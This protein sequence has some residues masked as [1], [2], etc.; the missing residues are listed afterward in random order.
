[1][2]IGSS[3]LSR[4]KRAAMRETVTATICNTSTKKKNSTKILSSKK[5][6]TSANSNKKTT[7]QTKEN[8]KKKAEMDDAEM[9]LISDPYRKRT[10]YC[11]PDIH[12]KK[13]QNC[14]DNPN[15][16]YGFVNSKV[17]IWGSHIALCNLSLGDNPHA[18]KRDL[19]SLKP[20]G[21]VNLGATCYVN[22]LLQVLFFD[23]VFRNALYS[24]KP[25]RLNNTSNN[26]NANN[27]NNFSHDLCEENSLTLSQKEIIESMQTTFAH[28][29]YGTT[30]SFNPRDF[31]SKLNLS[32]GIQQDGIEFNKLLLT[33]LE[34]IFLHASEKR[35]NTFVQDRY[36][37][38]LCYC[39]KCLKCGNVSKRNAPFYELELQIENC[40]S[41]NESL[42]MYF[43]HEELNG[44]NKYYCEMACMKKCDA[45]RYTEVCKLPKVINVQLMRF[46]F[47]MTTFRKKK[48]KN[49]IKIP[50]KLSSTDFLGSDLSNSSNGASISNPVIYDLVAVL[51]HRGSSADSG[52]YVADIKT[53]D[54]KWWNCNDELTEKKTFNKS[55]K[56]KSKDKKANTKASAAT[57]TESSSKNN[58]SDLIDVSDDDKK[59]NLFSTKDAEID[60]ASKEFLKNAIYFGNPSQ[61]AYM[62]VYRQ[63]EVDIISVSSKKNKN[64]DEN[65]VNDKP[66]F[67]QNVEK[68][69]NEFDLS[70]QHYD[71]EKDKLYK[72]LNARVESYKEAFVNV[73]DGN[74]QPYVQPNE[75]ED[76]INSN[77]V[78]VPTKWLQSFIVGQ[79][80]VPKKVKS[81]STNIVSTVGKIQESD[82]IN[83]VDDNDE[84]KNGAAA[85]AAGVTKINQRDIYDAPPD[86]SDIVCVHSTHQNCCFSPKLVPKLKLMRTLNLKVLISKSK[87][88]KIEMFKC[89]ECETCRKEFR[90]EFSDNASL[91]NKW[92]ELKTAI[93]KDKNELSREKSIVPLISKEW[94]KRLKDNIKTLENYRKNTIVG[95]LVF[96]PKR[97]ILD[98]FQ[99]VKS[100]ENQDVKIIENG[101]LMAPS[102]EN[103]GRPT[104]KS[105]A[106]DLGKSFSNAIES[107]KSEVVNKNVLCEHNSLI[108]NFGVKTQ[109][110]SEGTWKKIF[111]HFTNSD[112]KLTLAS[113]CPICKDASDEVKSDTKAKKTM[114]QNRVSQF[115]ND[116]VL[117]P[118]IKRHKKQFHPDKSKRNAGKEKE[119]MFLP[120]NPGVYRILS[121]TWLMKWREFCHSAKKPEPEPFTHH[122]C[123]CMCTDNQCT[124]LPSSLK[125]WLEMTREKTYGKYL[126][127]LPQA[128]ISTMSKEIEIVSDD[129]WNRLNCY[130]RSQVSTNTDASGTKNTMMEPVAFSILPGKSN[131]FTPNLCKKCEDQQSSREA[132]EKIEF[133]NKEIDVM[134]LKKDTII[135]DV[136]ATKESQLNSTVGTKIGSTKRRRSKR[137]NALGTTKSVLVSSSDKVSLL[138]M[139]LLEQFTEIDDTNLGLL[140]LYKG[141]QKLDNESTLRESRIRLGDVLLLRVLDDFDDPDAEDLQLADVFSNSD[142]KKKESRV[143]RGF[144]G[145]VFQS[146]VKKKSVTNSENSINLTEQNA[147]DLTTLSPNRPAKRSKPS[148]D[149]LNYGTNDVNIIM[150]NAINKEEDAMDVDNDLSPSQDS[151][152]SQKSEY[153]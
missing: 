131:T 2:V 62:L 23:K 26:K 38:Q 16:L 151:I 150:D 111:K 69:N 149:D 32:T 66:I 108:H 57:I 80:V 1:M 22:S 114:W 113:V 41:V 34:Q 39:T 94:I 143:E 102:T 51:Y 43:N 115:T 11:H 145:S 42:Q 5:K 137:S 67:V 14:S 121:R 138:K 54:G 58:T 100:V 86:F 63:R 85:N 8:A 47:D 89:V 12:S 140:V 104:L 53:L 61:N 136:I 112:L 52:H 21:L 45:E 92:L 30:M 124:L 72:A 128:T 18:R 84:I 3:N 127:D 76:D 90:K 56:G 105:V 31:V 107:F 109:K 123:Y 28:M 118:L 95:K 110:I 15:C 59:V 117:K 81:I 70:V 49:A 17:G 146:A 125:N 122:P 20:C 101:D 33:M 29:Q 79:E 46:V 60:E 77:F 120:L 7:R 106:S 44:D 135:D 37:G 36:G 19:E 98:H 130:Y 35:L 139:K 83:L 129:Q 6:K 147:I 71:I 153:F 75:N 78:W 40:K 91:L 116:K 133:E 99:K 65:S 142:V 152:S 141:K 73:K 88:V 48:V 132:D 64:T 13:K 55:N 103:N 50:L 144:Q 24:W 93:D 126:E 10:E 148:N 4:S 134:K 27:I 68:S 82:V 74:L 25:K 96:E 9:K 87:N 97:N 119:T